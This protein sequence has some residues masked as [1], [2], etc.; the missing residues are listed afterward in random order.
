MH[1]RE[2]M[3]PADT[4][5]WVARYWTMTVPAS[6][7][8][9]FGHRILPDG[10]VDLVVAVRPAA[11]AIVAVRGPRATPLVLPVGP[12]D[13]YFGV[14]FWPDAGA[15][16]LGT[17]AASL[18]DHLGPAASFIGADAEALGEAFVPPPDETAAPAL[19]AEWLVPRVA[20]LPPVDPAVRLAIV[21]ANAAGGAARATDL[22]PLVGLGAR[23]L[24]RR[25]VRAT[26]LT[27]KTYSRIRRLRRT[28]DHLLAGEPRTWSQ[29][30]ATLGFADHSHLAGEFA[31]LAGAA[32]TEIAA[33]VAG[34]RHVDV[35]P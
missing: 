29:V 12:G 16:V 25:F 33:Y 11:P 8:P 19:F 22:A 32:P 21:A 13:R 20:T 10:C 2:F 18:V 7:E 14:R 23:Q 15:L 30:A 5:D 3:P 28:L 6:V 9:G 24:Q 27:I 35:V 34:I 17:S 26:G 31:R 1:Y 4:A